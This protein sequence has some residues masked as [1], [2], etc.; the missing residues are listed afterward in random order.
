MGIG[1][2]LAA[3]SSGITKEITMLA[4]IFRLFINGLLSPPKA[5]RAF[6]AIQR[7]GLNL[8]ALLAMGSSPELTLFDGLRSSNLSQLAQAI[9]RRA[10]YLYEAAHIQ[11]K[12]KVLL[13]ARNGF[14]FIELLF[15]SAYLGA[16]VYIMSPHFKAAVY[17]DFIAT[18]GIDCVLADADIDFDFEQCNIPVFFTHAAAPVSHRQLP[19]K[20]WHIGK[21]ILLTSGSTGKPKMATRQASPW[22]FVDPLIDIYRQLHLKQCQSLAIAVP[23][24]H[25]YGLA[26][27]VMA[28]FLDKNIE[29]SRKFHPKNLAQRIQA[30]QVDSIVLVPTI[31]DRLVHQAPASLSQLKCI[32][33]GSD[34]LA[35]SL[36]NATNRLVSN[37][38]H[39][40]YGTSEAGVA[41]I[42][43]PEVLLRYPSTIGRPIHGVRATIAHPNSQGIGMLEIACAW[44]M[45]GCEQHA[46]STGDLAHRNAS[47]YYFL[48]GRQ[49]ERLVIDGENI[50]PANVANLIL[51]NQSIEWA[52]VVGVELGGRT[53]YLA[54]QIVVRQS[55]AF[56]QSAFERW[57]QIHLPVYLQPKTIEVL[58]EPAPSKLLAV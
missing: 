26:A 13:V 12:S 1:L 53:A 52:R 5:W 32:I 23:M 29:F 51:E 30:N 41:F 4:S 43:T 45:N 58:H 6:W 17:Q 34:R 25:S 56:D 49:D 37:A 35:P 2:A 7:Y 14:G 20:T 39:S 38:L 9:D 18:Q 50:Y 46:V 48:D 28:L 33:S 27:L 15:A 55:Q 16:D 54:A 3:H 40:L 31:L 57:L 21:L 19:A 11:A 42:A 44:V 10:V 22:L 8:R 47:G 36:V 24:F